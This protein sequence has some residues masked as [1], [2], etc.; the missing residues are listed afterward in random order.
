MTV[1]QLRRLL[2]APEIVAPL[3]AA[4]YPSHWSIDASDAPEEQPIAEISSTLQLAHFRP[5]MREGPHFP[6]PQSVRLILGESP[7]P[8]PVPEGS[9]QVTATLPS[10]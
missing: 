9:W 5:H 1:D 3:A 8:V 4:G 7:Q 10:Q 2:I 6:D